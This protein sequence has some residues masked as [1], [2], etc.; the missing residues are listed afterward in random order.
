M[1]RPGVGVVRDKDLNLE[2]DI[3]S[4]TKWI[5]LPTLDLEVIIQVVLGSNCVTNI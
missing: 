2:D 5:M 3:I 4:H 1:K